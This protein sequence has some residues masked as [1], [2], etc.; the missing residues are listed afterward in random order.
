[1]L[2]DSELFRHTFNGRS[3]LIERSMFRLIPADQVLNI[4]S[5]DW[6]VP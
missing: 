1:M 5:Y 3:F 2:Q 4:L 6:I